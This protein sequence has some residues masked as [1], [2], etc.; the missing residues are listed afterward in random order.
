MRKR[1]T[2]VLSLNTSGNQ[3]SPGSGIGSDTVNG[4][5]VDAADTPC[6]SLGRWRG[7]GGGGGDEA[8]V[9]V[10]MLLTS[11][12]PPLGGGAGGVE[13]CSSGMKLD[14]VVCVVFILS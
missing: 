3:P 4:G 11:W 1:K 5:G 9:G 8:V 10:L 2:Y 14:I 6:A 7:N 13:L 12:L